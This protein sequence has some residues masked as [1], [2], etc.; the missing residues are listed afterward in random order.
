MNL[1][2]KKP[3][4]KNAQKID[5][6]PVGPQP[7]LPAA[8]R[9][10]GLH[11]LSPWEYLQAVWDFDKKEGRIPWGG[12]PKPPPSISACYKHMRALGREYGNWLESRLQH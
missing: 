4:G 8:F 11:D 1:V 5:L 12:L 7:P 9:P 2:Y 10:P 6:P 3:T